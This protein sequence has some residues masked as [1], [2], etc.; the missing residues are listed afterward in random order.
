VRHALKR[1]GGNIKLAVLLAEGCDLNAA[2]ALLERA[3]G[4]LGAAVALA[5]QKSE[6]QRSA[7]A[8]SLTSDF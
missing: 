7:A 2:M 1:A 3:G 6:S 8:K 4:R 5:R